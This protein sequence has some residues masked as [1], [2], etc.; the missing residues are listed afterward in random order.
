MGTATWNALVEAG[1]ALGDRLLYLRAPMLR[2]DD[3]AEL[4]H[5]LGGLGFDAGRVDGILGPR[6][7]AALTDFQHNAGVVADGICG[8]ATVRLLRALS[9]RTTSPGQGI[10]AL[11]EADRLR[12]VP[13][14]L[15]AQRV[16]VGESGGADSLARATG[17]ALQRAGARVLTL[18]DPDEST[19]ARLANAF[20]ATLYLGLRVAE[21]A[22][23]SYYAT[24]GFES[25]GGRAAAALL[26]EHTGAVLG[27]CARP[28]GMRLTVLRET[29]M[30]AVVCCLAPPALVV[31][32]TSEL[33]LAITTAVGSWA[34]QPLPD[35]RAE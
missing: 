6:T 33:A 20:G 12:S 14:T 21:Q 9:S 28:C 22:A 4:Q 32:H 31:T 25:A 18:P 8:T 34:C 17:R 13:A 23:I 2:G 10:A 7:A 5:L 35:S 19:Q 15:D 11:K 26:A 1:Y 29:R 24:T 30:P 3:V 27:S 16:V